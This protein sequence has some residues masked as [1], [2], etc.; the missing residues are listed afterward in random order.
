MKR[1]CM[2]ILALT[3][4]L[5]LSVFLLTGCTIPGAS[6]SGT[7]GS[8]SS[9]GG[10]D[11]GG[12]E[13]GGSEEGGSEEGDNELPNE[14]IGGFL[15]LRYDDKYAFDRLT[16]SMSSEDLNTPMMLYAVYN[17]S[18]ENLWLN[19]D[20]VGFAAEAKE[21]FAEG[22]NTVYGFEIPTET[23]AI[24][25][26]DFEYQLTVTCGTDG[27]DIAINYVEFVIVDGNY[28]QPDEGGEGS[29]S[30]EIDKGDPNLSPE[31]VGLYDVKMQSMVADWLWVMPNADV[32]LYLLFRNRLPEFAGVEILGNRIEGDAVG[33][34]TVTDE[35]CYAYRVAFTAPADEG[36][37][38][39]NLL[40]EMGG[41]ECGQSIRL[42]VD[43]AMDNPSG[44]AGELVGVRGENGTEYLVNANINVSSKI[45]VFVAYTA[46]VSNLSAWIYGLGLQ[47]VVLSETT[48]GSYTVYELRFDGVYT[49]NEG[50]VQYISLMHGSSG[51]DVMS[52]E[53]RLTFGYFESN[54]EPV[55]D[56]PRI[57]G[58]N[59]DGKSVPES[60]LVYIDGDKAQRLYIYV[61]KQVTAE[62][63]LMSD[64]NT[65]TDFQ[66]D[67][68][69]G[70][71]VVSFE[72]PA[73]EKNGYKTALVC[74]Y[75][76]EQL[77]LW[78]G[79]E[80]TVGI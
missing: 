45:H 29:G 21:S 59:S 34:I 53:V 11:E 37:F 22:D 71:T 41:E 15:G 1:I 2:L 68:R 54:D 13:E 47:G 9:A 49:V 39:L 40:W 76:G 16:V 60:D 51:M 23:L 66:V 8:G 46:P 58:V 63:I 20:A 42:T 44:Q 30:T 48:E 77:T 72:Y 17:R 64:G 69:D 4:S 5:S 43:D 74:N 3:L 24:L 50:D 78:F 52:Q 56:Y 62:H 80:V 31:Y 27:A 75:N 19:I 73:M 38:A 79:V 57:V 25:S 67:E 35:V 70:Y 26:Y 55:Y 28:V 10:S 12:S 32:E 7:G 65:V 18:V 33:S 36:E 6:G 61:D 14:G